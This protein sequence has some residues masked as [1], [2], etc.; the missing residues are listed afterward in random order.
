LAR[1][2]LSSCGD[3]ASIAALPV[4]EKISLPFAPK[5]KPAD[6]VVLRPKLHHLRSEK[7]VLPK[8]FMLIDPAF[9]PD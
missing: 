8:V 2:Q 7:L 1:T 5:A 9:P 4:L 6:Q 3:R